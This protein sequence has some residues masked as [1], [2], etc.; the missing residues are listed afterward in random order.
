MTQTDPC[1]TP[2]IPGFL[3]SFHPM[4]QVELVDLNHDRLT[5]MICFFTDC[6]AEKRPCSATDCEKKKLDPAHRLVDDITNCPCRC[7]GIYYEVIM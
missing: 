2:F 1:I 6:P 5:I 7:T 4:E 3:L